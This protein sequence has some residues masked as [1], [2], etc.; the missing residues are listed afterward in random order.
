MGNLIV[1]RGCLVEFLVVLVMGGLFWSFC[2]S[3]KIRV[4]D[5]MLLYAVFY[6][7]CYERRVVEVVF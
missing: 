4:V 5:V 2:N 1:L 7:L 3:F 6:V